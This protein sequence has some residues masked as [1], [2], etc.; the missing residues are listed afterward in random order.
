MW[1]SQTCKG[2]IRKSS[3]RPF[4]SYATSKVSFAF[5][6]TKPD[7]QETKECVVSVFE[8]TS[9]I[10]ITRYCWN[11]N[12]NKILKL[13]PTRQRISIVATRHKFATEAHLNVR[14]RKRIK[15]QL[16]INRWRNSRHSS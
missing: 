14:S 3:S 10:A 13:F 7:K 12:A 9:Y 6:G 15:V 4:V 1:I 11:S 16:C 8:G 5:P 2:P